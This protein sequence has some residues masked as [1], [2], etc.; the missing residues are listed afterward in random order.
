MNRDS[1]KAGLHDK[2]SIDGCLLI[3]YI[4]HCASFAILLQKLSE[5][6]LDPYLIRWIR[7]Y[8]AGRSQFISIDGC[9]S[10]TLSVL[11][12]VPQGLV[13]GPL[14]FVSYIND[15]AA[16]I[17]SGSN[18]NMFANDIALYRVIKTRDDYVYLQ[19]DVNSISTCIE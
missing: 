12:G 3:L 10:P 13:L 15:V 8:L 19:K 4:V 18:V 2:Y 14:L 11:S 16:A 5:I 7:S 17:S 1:G 9:D 6:S